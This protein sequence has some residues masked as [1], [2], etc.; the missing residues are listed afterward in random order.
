MVEMEQ[1][2]AFSTAGLSAQ[3]SLE[4]WRQAM[5]EVYYRLDIVP[6]GS[7]QLNGELVDWQLESLGV[8]N[9]KADSQRVIRRKQAAK[10]D[11]S[12]DFVF[13]FPIHQQMQFEQRGRSGAVEPGGV[14]LVNSAE[15][16]IIDVPDGSENITLKVDRDA[17]KDRVKNIDARCARLN[18][19]NPH[20][21]PVVSQLGFQLLK[22]QEC[23]NSL[24]LQDTVLELIC[25][26]LE[27]NEGADNLELVR[28]PL[29]SILF[30]RIRG[31]MRRH[32][33]DPDLSPERAAH[34]HK[35]SVRYLQKI[36]QLNQTTFGREL[37]EMRLQEAHRLLVDTARHFRGRIN[38]GQIAFACGFNNQAH[39]S[40]RYRERFGTA[41]R[42]CVDTSIGKPGE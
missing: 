8:S 25:L 4:S 5:A 31:Y 37:M 33:R 41:P 39:F 9:F 35:I 16:Y 18:I 20:L 6:T 10:I 3:K 2:H 24:R 29:A 12:E 28:Q 1:R 17:L 22:V 23:G 40:A 21:V 13:L 30:D 34:A 27:L 11:G 7:A 14:F 26:M 19:A 15:D 36:F 32:F 42:D 38:I